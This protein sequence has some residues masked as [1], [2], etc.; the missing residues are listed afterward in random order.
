[1]ASAA[2]LS[3]AHKRGS[4]A[5][6]GRLADF[7]C[8]GRTPG[9]EGT[10]RRRG[11]PWGIPG[12]DRPNADRS[13]GR[14]RCLMS[15]KAISTGFLWCCLAPHETWKWLRRHEVEGPVSVRPRPPRTA[16]LL[17]ALDSGTKPDLPCL[18]IVHVATRNAPRPAMR[19]FSNHQLNLM[20]RALERAL[21]L[22]RGKQRSDITTADLLGGILQA[23]EEGVWTEGL[24]AERAIEYVQSTTAPPMSVRRNDFSNL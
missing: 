8:A 17:L 4:R 11:P 15:V 20:S 6:L 12:R 16:G 19:D 5:L 24:M 13:R 14:W 9:A 1:M 21:T 22:L 3:N 7:V 2:L 23:A 10:A 18:I